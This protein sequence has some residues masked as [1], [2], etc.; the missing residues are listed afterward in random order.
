MTLGFG[1][2]HDL[3]VAGSRPVSGSVL[4]GGLLEILTLFC[5]FKGL[6][7][8]LRERERRRRVRGRERISSRP[9]LSTEP[10]TGLDP[11]TLRS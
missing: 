10:D 5:F 1:S 4:S 6:F 11:A 3:R 7:I 9:P 2:G 8:Y